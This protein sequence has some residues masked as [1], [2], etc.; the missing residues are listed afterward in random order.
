MTKP[1]D[2]VAEI[3]AAVR[4]SRAQPW[5]C[6][7]APEHR[8]TVEAIAAAYKAGKFGGSQKAV[9]EAIAKTLTARG[10]ARIGRHGVVAWLAKL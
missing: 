9:A 3:A 4:P 6:C 7:L 2:I 8:A 5:H 1:T 10:I